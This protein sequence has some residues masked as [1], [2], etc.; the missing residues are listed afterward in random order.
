MT[1][2]FNNVLLGSAS[3]TKQRPHQISAMGGRWMVETIIELRDIGK[4]QDGELSLELN[5]LRVSVQIWI[6]RKC[7]DI[8]I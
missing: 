5:E 3:L 6:F 2:P 1:I 8:Q 4:T 7:L